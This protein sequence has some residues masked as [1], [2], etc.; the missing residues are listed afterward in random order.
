[1]LISGFNL[2]CFKPLDLLN[3]GGHYSMHTLNS[4]RGLLYIL[5]SYFS[6]FMKK[7]SPVKGMALMPTILEL[8][9]YL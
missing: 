9:F 7:V 4:T 6:L 2:I 8:L 1:M 5:Q 3:R